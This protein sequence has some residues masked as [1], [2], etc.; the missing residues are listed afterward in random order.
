MIL[1]LPSQKLYIISSLVFSLEERE[2]TIHSECIGF[3]P[4]IG[5]DKNS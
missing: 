2:S 5:V 1:E 3:T 4:G